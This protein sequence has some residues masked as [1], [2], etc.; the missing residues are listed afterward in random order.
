MTI[1]GEN[2][3]YMSELVS[4]KSVQMS[5]RNKRALDAYH[6]VM[7]NMS[8]AAR[9]FIGK[10]FTSLPLESNRKMDPSIEEF[11]NFLD[12]LTGDD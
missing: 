10:P 7:N 6:Y 5:S 11:N 4:H 3:D 9:L 12:C 8:N 2:F 1:F